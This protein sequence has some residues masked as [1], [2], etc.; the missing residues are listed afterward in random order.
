MQDAKLQK[1]S[2]HSSTHLDL[3]AEIRP[4]HAPTRRCR[5][6]D[7]AIPPATPQKA[8]RH[9][10]CAATIRA[11]SPPCSEQYINAEQLAGIHGEF[12]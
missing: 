11:G 3:H 12:N 1:F 4:V 8:G 5:S 10:L 7:Q 9:S 6:V 2:M